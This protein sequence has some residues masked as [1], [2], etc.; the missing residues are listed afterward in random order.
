MAGR[1]EDDGEAMCARRRNHVKTTARGWQ[2]DAQSRVTLWRA[3]LRPFGQN[4]LQSRA[5]FR[6]SNSRFAIA[7]HQALPIGI[8][9]IRIV[10]VQ[11]QPVLQSIAEITSN[12]FMRDEYLPL[13][14]VNT[15]IY[16]HDGRMM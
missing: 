9:P 4:P 15:R 12:L 1:C 16:E 14:R 3:P 5:R 10:I 11:R 13:E 6:I 2:H 8:R 7:P